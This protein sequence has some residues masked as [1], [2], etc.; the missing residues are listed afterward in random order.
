MPPLLPG[1]RI[2]ARCTRCKDITGHIIVIM[3]EGKVAKVECCACH[4]IHKY[5]PPEGTVKP[6]KAKPV[7][8]QSGQER[9]QVVAAVKT[10]RPKVEKPARV[11]A[12]TK[13]A[14][15]AEELAQQWAVAVNR[16]AG[17]PAPYAMD[18][19]FRNGD[20]V[21]HKVFGV[22]QVLQVTPPDKMEIL[23]REGMKTLR[24]KC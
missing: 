12:P 21:D 20:F 24:C 11:S 13:A 4:S 18:A 19:A 8:V 2:E 16:F 9:Q 6:V 7:R 14:Q 3:L 10:P 15:H 5:Y 23:F 17:S 1:Q 22:G